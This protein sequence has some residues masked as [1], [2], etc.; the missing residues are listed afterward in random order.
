MEFGLKNTNGDLWL[1][2]QSILTQVKKSV[3]KGLNCYHFSPTNLNVTKETKSKKA[4]AQRDPQN[5][6]LAKKG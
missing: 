4:V 1:K 6:N 3:K 2:S 5:V